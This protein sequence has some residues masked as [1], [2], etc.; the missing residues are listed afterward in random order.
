MGMSLREVIFD[1]GGGIKD[2]KAFKA[3]QLGGPSGGCIPQELLDTPVEYEA[4]N[5]TGA[6]VGSGGMVVMDED[7][8]MVEMARFFLEFTCRE[9][10]GKCTYCRIGTRRML[11]I[12]E[13]ITSGS[14]TMKDIDLLEELSGKIKEGSLCGL[15]Q[16]APNPVLTTLKYFRH[17]YEEHV[18]EGKCRAAAC[19]NLL[20]YDIIE[21]DCIGC[22]L[23]AKVCPTKLLLAT[24]RNHI[25]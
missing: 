24:S 13:R 15:G 12:L 6:I 19:H 25:A 8:C 1:I 16:T 17:E 20:T 10:C 7:T 22:T 9:S 18:L 5:Q 11:E 14:G 2:G 21:S 3:V 23:C 4:I